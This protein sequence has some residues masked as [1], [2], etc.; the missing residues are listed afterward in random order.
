M[1]GHPC[2]IETT[3][4]VLPLW[5]DETMVVAGF[6]VPDEFQFSTDKWHTVH[7]KQDHCNR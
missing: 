3:E 1:I 5:T 7:I 6:S 2:S 4:D